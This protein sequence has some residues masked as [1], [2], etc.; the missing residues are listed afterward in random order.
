MRIGSLLFLLV[1]FSSVT[2]FA[3]DSCIVFWP[4][5]TTDEADTTLAWNPDSTHVDTCGTQPPYRI[6]YCR[7]SYHLTFDWR[8]INSPVVSDTALVYEWTDIDTLYP[9][10]RSV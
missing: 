8:V 7:S 3:Q 4:G 9:S 6:M 2:C 5:T 1:L 10:I